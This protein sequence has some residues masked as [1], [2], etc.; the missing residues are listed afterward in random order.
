MS[1]F[2][3]TIALAD[4]LAPYHNHIRPSPAAV[5]A[6]VTKQAGSRTLKIADLRPQN[7]S[8]INGHTK[9]DEEAPVVKDAPEIVSKF[10]DGMTQVDELSMSCR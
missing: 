9:K 7:G 8:A 3:Y 1:F 10:F 2:D 4:W 6:E 5:L